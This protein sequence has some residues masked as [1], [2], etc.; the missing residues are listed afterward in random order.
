MGQLGL[1]V[2]LA[3]YAVFE[4]YLPAENQDI[5]IFLTEMISGKH[6]TPS[7]WLWG[8]NSSGKSHLLQAVCERLHD[9]AI[10]LPMEE[11]INEDP[12][13][14]T[15]LATR[16]FI[17]VDDIHLCVKKNHWE[18]A[19]FELF[20]RLIELHSTLLV[21]SLHAPKTNNF[22]LSDLTSRFSQYS[23]FK[24]KSL[25]D[26]DC[27]S[28]LQL[29]AKQRGLVLPDDTVNYMLTHKQRDMK[30]LYDLLDKLDTESLAAKRK[31]TVPFLKSVMNELV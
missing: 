15:D 29:R 16:R 10:Y 4:S 6:Y 9:N 19:F 25:N 26:E 23:V 3:D 13:L 30:I 12:S 21:S 20:N 28:A 14:L 27:K 1:P 2:K 5:L 31:L 7:C 18:L 22:K 24:M 11:L 17:C 8:A